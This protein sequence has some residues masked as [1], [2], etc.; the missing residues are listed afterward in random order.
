MGYVVANASK[1][2]LIVW[3]M[4]ALL[5]VPWGEIAAAI[6]T[7]EYKSRRCV[8]IGGDRVFDWGIS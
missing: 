2:K 8:T 7:V 3:Y 5:S 4:T 1:S 6:L